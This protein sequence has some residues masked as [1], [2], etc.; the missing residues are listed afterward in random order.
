MAQVCIAWVFEWDG[1]VR[2]NASGTRAHN[3]HS[4][5]CERSLIDVVRDKDSRPSIAF[6]QAQ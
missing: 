5:G 1:N 4:V 6:P 2:D 3:E